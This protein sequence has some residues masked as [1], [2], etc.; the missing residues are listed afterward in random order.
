MRNRTVIGVCCLVL[1]AVPPVHGQ[2]SDELKA[3]FLSEAPAKW[4]EYR[5]LAKK[6]QGQAKAHLL[7][8]HQNRVLKKGKYTWQF[9]QNLACARLFESRWDNDEEAKRQERK[10]VQWEKIEACN[11]KYSFYLRQGTAADGWVLGKLALKPET[12]PGAD[13]EKLS[14]DIYRHVAGAFDFLGGHM[15]EML[16][17]REFSVIKADWVDHDGRRV[18]RLEALVV[19]KVRFPPE[20]DLVPATMI[21]DPDRYWCCL[22]EQA[23]YVTKTGQRAVFT[24][25]NEVGTGSQKIP[26]IKRRSLQFTFKD[27]E[28]KPVG[29]WQSV[30]DF[31]LYEDSAVPESEFTLTA[32]GLPEPQGIEWPKPTRW[33][34]WGTAAGLAMIVASGI[35]ARFVRR[36][37]QARAAVH[38]GAAPTGIGR[39]AL[40]P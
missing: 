36:R 3:R 10:L 37:Q 25:Q 8:E 40:Q 16:D 22:G 11:T 7:L 33:W 24:S 13:P 23:D 1:C 4:Q 38:S 35:A 21:L 5:E 15:T 17:H 28:G 29:T 32:F 30:S 12:L 9:K 19:P 18:V 39:P 14:K 31:D 20:K 27:S 6:L 2:H 34:L 26:I